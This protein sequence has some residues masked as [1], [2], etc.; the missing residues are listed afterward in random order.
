MFA[1]ENEYQTHSSDPRRVA[2]VVGRFVGKCRG[3][4]FYS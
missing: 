3:F 4:Y 1:D 2:V